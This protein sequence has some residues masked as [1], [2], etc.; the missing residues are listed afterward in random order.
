MD[1]IMINLVLNAPITSGHCNGP[2]LFESSNPVTP[3]G[4][5]VYQS[6]FFLSNDFVS[7]AN[8]QKSDIEK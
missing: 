4:T 3:V 8:E 5:Y 6:N 1:K 7:K 2:A